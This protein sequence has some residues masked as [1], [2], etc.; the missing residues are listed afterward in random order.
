MNSQ[1][2]DR[3]LFAPEWEP[4]RRFRLRD[5]PSALRGWLLDPGSL[6]QRVQCACLGHF[7]V[8]LLAQEWGRPADNEAVVLQM[9]LGT[10][11]LVRQVRLLCNDI[12]WVYART[13]I[14]RSSL[15]GRQRRLGNLGTRS[16]GSVLFADRS[17]RRGELELAR[18]SGADPLLRR[19][20]SGL[21]SLP[22]EVWG[23]RSVF[24]LGGKPLLVSEFFL[25]P[26]TDRSKR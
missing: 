16:L 24:L 10:W 23:R 2:S 18:L 1:S 4:Y 14:P 9:R 7:R 6:T 3:R 15:R 19:A 25:P 8:E 20:A 12:P 26:V 21:E 22:N 5:I 11:A 17:M 13:V